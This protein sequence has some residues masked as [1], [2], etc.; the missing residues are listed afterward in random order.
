MSQA[1][2]ITDRTS[3]TSTM[4]RLR[5]PPENFM[6]LKVIFPKHHVKFLSKDHPTSAATSLHRSGL[7]DWHIYR[8]PKV[9]MFK[10]HNEA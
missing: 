3:P 6:L 10:N 5:Q 7:D 1:T 9:I 8:L 4:P 2:A